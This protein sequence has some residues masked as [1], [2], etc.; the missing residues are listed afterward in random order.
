MDQPVEAML[1]PPSEEYWP[2]SMAVLTLEST[3]RVVASPRLAVTMG[4]A[5]TKK[6]RSRLGGATLW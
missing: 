6:A 3:L 5:S 4:T 1:V 2:L